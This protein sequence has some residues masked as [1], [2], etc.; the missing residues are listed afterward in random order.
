M[1]KESTSLPTLNFNHQRGVSFAAEKQ[2]TN[3]IAPV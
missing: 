1:I 3:A 2:T